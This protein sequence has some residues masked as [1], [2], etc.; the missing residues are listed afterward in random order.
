[1]S[2][3]LDVIAVFFAAFA[4]AIVSRKAADDF[5]LGVVAGFEIFAAVL[6]CRGIAAELFRFDASL[7]LG[8]VAIVFS[9]CERGRNKLLL[10]TEDL[11]VESDLL[12]SLKIESSATF[13]S[14]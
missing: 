11:D 1:M 5:E 7:E 6:A 9:P 8:E 13:S 10:L 12:G 3:V 4:F 2:L 14:L